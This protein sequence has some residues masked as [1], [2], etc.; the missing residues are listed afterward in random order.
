MKHDFDLD[1]VVLWGN[2]WHGI[3]SDG[4][5]VTSVGEK[6]L[7]WIQPD[8][9]DCFLVKAPGIDEVPRTLEQLAIDDAAG[10]EWLNYALLTGWYE[11]QLYGKPMS[12]GADAN[13][14]WSVTLN[15]TAGNTALTGSI[16]FSRLE[17]ESTEQQTISGL[18]LSVTWPAS[19]G[20]YWDVIAVS[21]DGSRILLGL[22]ADGNGAAVGTRY[23]YTKTYPHYRARVFVNS[24]GSSS[25]WSKYFN[26]VVAPQQYALI[27]LSGGDSTEDEITANLSILKALSDTSTAIKNGTSTATPTNKFLYS[28]NDGVNSFYE[29]RD[30]MGGGGSLVAS[31]P[32]DG[33]A[34]SEYETESIVG[35]YFEGHTVKWVKVRE[36]MT[37]DTLYSYT[38]PDPVPLPAGPGNHLRHQD[39]NVAGE[40]WLD[41]DGDKVSSVVFESADTVTLQ[42]NEFNTGQVDLG[43]S[44]TGSATAD[45]IG[46]YSE[47]KSTTYL[48]TLPADQDLRPELGGNAGIAANRGWL[49][50]DVHGL[51]YAA[52][53]YGLVL[54][55][56][57]SVGTGGIARS[58]Y[59]CGLVSTVTK[60]RESAIGTVAS[61]GSNLVRY[62]YEHYKASH[63]PVTGEILLNAGVWV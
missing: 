29:F 21:E 4:T 53:C 42:V 18:S 33:P 23:V 46:I 38:L 37:L 7:S 1:E 24:S 40:I 63:H 41:M 51:M 32:Y 39:S 19:N 58:I 61:A 17:L 43:G 13:Q 20:E 36:T 16:V 28:T 54:D 6:S 48:N 8:S 14:R 45:G 25:I 27:E 11:R 44:A 47:T 62:V 3:V 56:N 34:S 2:P 26:R 22:W 9:G 55:I 57:A 49:S 10:A 30:T 35:G 50:L 15:L 31:L 5:L 59:A 60:D 12:A 52:G